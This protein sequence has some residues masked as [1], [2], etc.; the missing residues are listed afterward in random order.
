MIFF[1]AG[2]AVRKVFPDHVPYAEHYGVWKRG[3]EPLRQAL[4]ETWKP[5]LESK[6]TRDEALKA[7]LKRCSSIE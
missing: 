1:T 6:S 5:Y 4:E 7:L 3:W 2:E